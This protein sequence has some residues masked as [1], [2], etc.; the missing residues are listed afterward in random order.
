MSDPQTIDGILIG[1][2]IATFG[3]G[4]AAL[5]QFADHCFERA[6]RKKEIRRQ[7]YEEMGIFYAECLEWYQ[8]LAVCKSSEDIL[9]NGFPSSD[10]RKMVMLSIIYFPEIVPYATN[11]ANAMGAFHNWA[12]KLT[13]G[14]TILGELIAKS[15]EKE[16][17]VE[18]FSIAKNAFDESI[19]R[20]SKKYNGA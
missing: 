19:L 18:K 1:G 9:I 14:K 6:Q 8:K 5:I 12:N 11:F 7:K 15:P 3:I 10:T 16:S 4:I 13:D 20:Y 2:A 17:E